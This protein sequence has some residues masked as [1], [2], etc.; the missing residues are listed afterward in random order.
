MHGIIYRHIGR[1]GL[2]W[3]QP[4]QYTHHNTTTGVPVELHT[5]L[6]IRHT[7]TFN[8]NTAT[9]VH[10]PQHDYWSTRR[11]TYSTTQ[12]ADTHTFNHN[13]ATGVHTPQHNYW[14]THRTTYSTIHQTHTHTQLQHSREWLHSLLSCS[15]ISSWEI[16]QP[17]L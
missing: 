13:T 16:W 4:L 6:F 2:G 17:Y 14:S 11:T 12:H 9:G 8:H 5:P 10:T 7:H 3:T 1:I 15:R